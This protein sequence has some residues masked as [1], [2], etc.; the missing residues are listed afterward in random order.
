MKSMSYLLLWF[1]F[2]SKT[3]WP[4]NDVFIEIKTFGPCRGE[5]HHEMRT[6]HEHQPSEQ[7]RINSNNYYNDVRAPQMQATHSD[8]EAQVQKE[9]D[10]LVSD[11][12]KSKNENGMY[13]ISTKWSSPVWWNVPAGAEQQHAIHDDTRCHGQTV[14]SGV[15]D[16]TV[17]IS[18]FTPGIPEQSPW[19]EVSTEV[20]ARMLADPWYTEKIIDDMMGL[21][22]FGGKFT[23]TLTTDATIEGYYTDTFTWFDPSSINIEELLG[24]PSDIPYDDYGL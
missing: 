7:C 10:E 22:Y 14:P 9:C 12:I 2:F 15:F 18:G 3:A 19:E 5:A 20:K 13:L 4:D 16:L 24:D 11:Y 23:M 8:A 6:Q 1:V 17:S 21:V